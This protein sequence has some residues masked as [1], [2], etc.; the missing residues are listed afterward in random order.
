MT[1]IS[2]LAREDIAELCALAREIWRRHYPPIIGEAQTE[3]MLAQRY[4]PDVIDSEL[5]QGGV[6]WDVL[7]Q[8][9]AIVGFA[10]SFPTTAPGEVKLDK[11]YIHHAHQRRGYGGRLLA[12]TCERA[13]RLGYDHVILA[14]NKRNATAIAAYRKHGF[15]IRDAVVKPIGGGFVMDDYVM[16]KRLDTGAHAGEPGQDGF[17]RADAREHGRSP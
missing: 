5:R 6:W 8:H 10:S 12:H 4:A 11:L 14:V 15:D 16:H 7:R 1:T 2:A 3:Y 13:R 9:R 17:A